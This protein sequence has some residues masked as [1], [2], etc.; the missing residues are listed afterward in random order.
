MKYRIIF[1]L[2]FLGFSNVRRHF[3]DDVV[4]RELT[5]AVS[6]LMLV[7]GSLIVIHALT[8][9]HCEGYVV[10]MGVGHS[11]LCLF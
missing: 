11:R 8:E 3:G 4:L 10:D 6:L 9:S 2:D 5:S 1:F 7:V